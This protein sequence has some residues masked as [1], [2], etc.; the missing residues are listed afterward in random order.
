MT[1]VH[2]WKCLLRVTPSG[3][4][5]ILDGEVSGPISPQAMGNACYEM[6]M[7]RRYA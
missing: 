3:R 7:W 1:F 6:K 2:C 4:R 5:L